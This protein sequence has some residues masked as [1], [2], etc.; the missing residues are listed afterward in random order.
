MLTPQKQQQQQQQNFVD[1]KH[2]F[3]CFDLHVWCMHLRMVD[4]CVQM[5][6]RMCACGGQEAMFVIFL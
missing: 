6:V 1:L 4:M 5:F 2:S 3:Y